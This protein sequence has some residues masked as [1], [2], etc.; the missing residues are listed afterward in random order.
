MQRLH[1][2]VL[3]ILKGEYLREQEMKIINFRKKKMKLWTKEQQELYE[4]VSVIF[5]K[6]NL[7]INIWKIKKYGGAAHSICNFKYGV[8]KKKSYSFGQWI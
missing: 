2:K 7:K 3:W 1:E 5:L 4:N 8:P 6:K